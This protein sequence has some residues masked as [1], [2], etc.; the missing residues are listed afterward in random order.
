MSTRSREIPHGY[1]EMP[2][3]REIPHG[4]REMPHG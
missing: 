2:H 3:G 1:R 4:Y